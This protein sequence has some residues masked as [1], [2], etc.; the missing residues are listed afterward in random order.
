[1]TNIKT[2]WFSTAITKDDVR[3]FRVNLNLDSLTY[4]DQKKALFLCAYHGK[5]KVFQ[6]LCKKHK[7]LKF[8]ALIEAIKGGSEEIVRWICSDRK[9]D[10]SMFGNIAF[11]YASLEKNKEIIEILTRDIRVMRSIVSDRA[12]QIVLRDACDVIC[13]DPEIQTEKSCPVCLDDFIMFQV[14]ASN[15]GSKQH[16]TCLRCRLQ[17]KKCPIC[18]GSLKVWEVE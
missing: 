11:V 13:F 16:V 4:E 1:M 8:R 18:R 6:L 3:T 5:Q 10:P 17:L 7:D 9:I 15:H 14:I 2:D 12:V